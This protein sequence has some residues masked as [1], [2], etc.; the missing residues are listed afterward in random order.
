MS[1]EISS[2]PYLFLLKFQS[3]VEQKLSKMF[4]RH[5]VRYI[6]TSRDCQQLQNLNKQYSYFEIHLTN[7]L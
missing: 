2:S 6:F 4:S 5:F 7:S 3:N 1:H